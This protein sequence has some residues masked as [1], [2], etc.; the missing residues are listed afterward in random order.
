LSRPEDWAADAER[1]ETPHVPE[2]V[3]FPEAGRI[4]ADLLRRNAPV[5]HAWIVGADECGRPSEVRPW[6]RQP[7]ERSVLDVPGPTTLRARER[8]RPP[9]RRS[10]GGRK[11]AV[12]CG[13]ADTWATRQ[14]AA[15]W[16]RFTVRD[17]EKGPLVVAAMTVRVR[18][19]PPRRSGPEKRLVVVR[20]VAAP[21]RTSSALSNAAPDVPLSELVR[22]PGPRPGIEELFESGKGEAG[23]APSEVRSWGG[24][25]H[26]VT[27]SLLALWFLGLERRQLGGENPGRDGVAGA[28]DLQPI[29][30]GPGPD[31]G[32]DRRG[33][34]PGGASERGVAHLPLVCGHPDLPPTS[35]AA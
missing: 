30:A 8:R 12:R 11:H 26:H 17:G 34:H 31:G 1:R 20:T 4:A 33:D 24:W 6:R 5:P 18:A 14:P 21:P 35:C 7:G 22:V 16:T 3:M 25:P 27:L 32:P 13:R 2:A 10:G 28:A 23:L 15:R 9:R 19:Q 29:V